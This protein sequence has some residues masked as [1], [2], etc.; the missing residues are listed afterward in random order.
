MPYP[1]RIGL[2][3][4][5]ALIGFVLSSLIDVPPQTWSLNILGSPLALT[6]SGPWLVTLL[7]AA[8]MCAG[9]DALVRGHPRVRPVE[10]GY[11]FTFWI[12]P[13]LVTVALALLMPRLWANLWLWIASLLGGAGLIA[14][15]LAGEYDTVDPNNRRYGLARLGLNSATYV[16]ALILFAAIYGARV[17]SL[18][19]ATAVALVGLLL[20]LELRETEQETG[21]T[22]LYALATGFVLGQATWALNY[23]PIDGLRGGLLLLLI[24]Y[25]LTGIV[26][27]HLDRRLTRRVWL[28]FGATGLAG[29]L[30]VVATAPW[31]R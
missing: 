25:A 26:Q 4:S 5:L 30:V 10:L 20:A 31:L 13:A 7:L 11:T 17:R 15:I 14:A 19:S 18:L 28:E 16:A 6:L 2:L 21:Q 24:F 29:F 9:T 23:W 12:L 3:T 8:I 27:H 1:N 22:W